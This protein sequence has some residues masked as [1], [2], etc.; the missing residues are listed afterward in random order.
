MTRQTRIVADVRCDLCGLG[1]AFLEDQFH[2]VGDVD[3]CSWCLH[4]RSVP[5]G[6]LSCGV[7]VVTFTTGSWSCSCGR[8]YWPALIPQRVV[9]AV[10]DVVAAAASAHVQGCNRAAR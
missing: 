5:G 2:Q 1:S 3:L 4:A 10:P 6:Q 8:H 9:E 7:H